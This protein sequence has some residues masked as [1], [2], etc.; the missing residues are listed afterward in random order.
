MVSKR[1]VS[2][3]YYA[4]PLY[5]KKR[6]TDSPKY[7]RYVYA[8]YAYSV[9]DYDRTGYLLKKFWNRAD[10]Y[11]YANKYARD[12]DYFYKAYVEREVIQYGLPSK[13]FSPKS[14]SPIDEIDYALADGCR[15]IRI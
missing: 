12:H 9:D 8:V 1:V 14:P 13:R 5:T 15:M 7:V 10:A 2:D 4:D 6:I 3:N 11:T